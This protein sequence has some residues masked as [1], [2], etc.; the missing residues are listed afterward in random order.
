MARNVEIK[1]RARDPMAIATKARELSGDPALAL[2]QADTFFN[3]PDGRLKLRVS[4]SGGGELIYYHR[5]D[6]AGP[7]TSDYEILRTPEPEP[8]RR[9]LA[10]ALGTR[11]EVRKKRR[12]FLVGQ[13]RVHLDEVEG[14]GDFLELEVVLAAGETPEHGAAVAGE[15][16]RALGVEES[17]LV[18]G[19]YVD[20]LATP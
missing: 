5:P 17:D 14:L 15:L 1:A 6:E 2:S 18:T 3:C 7:K 10:T 8:L 13:T 20:M 16:M 19:A 9:L 11:G 12:V 4:A